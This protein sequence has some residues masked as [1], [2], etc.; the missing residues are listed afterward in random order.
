MGFNGIYDDIA[1]GCDIASSLFGKIHH[2]MKK[3]G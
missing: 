3:T 1:S 2:A